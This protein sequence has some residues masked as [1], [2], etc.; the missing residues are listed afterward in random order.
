[1]HS[2]NIVGQ[3]IC[4]GEYLHDGVLRPASA[5]A[6][7]LNWNI[8]LPPCNYPGIFFPSTILPK[9]VASAVLLIQ[10]IHENT[11][12]LTPFCKNTL[13]AIRSKVHNTLF[14]NYIFTLSYTY[15]MLLSDEDGLRYITQKGRQS[16]ALSF[17]DN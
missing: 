6:Y 8:L 2:N 5:L 3:S 15:I 1:M 17:K 11:H 16:P 7:R 4:E 10:Q 13:D 12:Y 9:H 14:S